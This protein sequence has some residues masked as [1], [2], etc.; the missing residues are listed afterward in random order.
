MSLRPCDLHPARAKVAAERPAKV[1]AATPSAPPVAPVAAPVVAPAVA[2]ANDPAEKPK[3][4]R[5]KEALPGDL[6]STV[7]K[8]ISG[9]AKKE[10]FKTGQIL[11]ALG[12]ASARARVAR[13][14]ND[15]IANK[16]IKRHGDGRAAFYTVVE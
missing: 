11:D 13:V 5:S 9:F 2:P 15:M 8:I 14:L 12:D 6:A 16:V 3:E 10:Q 1:V 4:K 7:R